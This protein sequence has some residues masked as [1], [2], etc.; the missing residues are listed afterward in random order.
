[1]I[2][3][4]SSFALRSQISIAAVDA[5]KKRIECVQKKH[6]CSV[7]GRVEGEERHAHGGIEQL[8]QCLHILELSLCV[9]DRVIK[10]ACEDRWEYKVWK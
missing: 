2:G 8:H 5:W 3:K 10:C 1:M 4:S 9:C 6:S 7:D